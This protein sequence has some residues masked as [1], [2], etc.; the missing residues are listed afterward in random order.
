M[1]QQHNIHDAM[2]GSAHTISAHAATN[3]L[4]WPMVSLPLGMY[5]VHARDAMI[6]KFCV[7]RA[8]TFLTDGWCC[9]KDL[10]SAAA[11]LSNV[12]HIQSPGM[13]IW[14]CGTR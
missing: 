7:M 3:N 5:E 12:I 4:T 8:K 10:S 2:K 9:I 14:L 6:R 1:E 13:N 11:A